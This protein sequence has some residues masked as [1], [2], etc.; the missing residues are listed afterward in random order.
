M[1]ATKLELSIWVTSD[2]KFDIGN[3][4]IGYPPDPENLIP[5]VGIYEVAPARCRH[6]CSTK[7]HAPF[8]KKIFAAS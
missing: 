6:E 7:V 8:L 3:F 5:V 2:T 1:R 4:L